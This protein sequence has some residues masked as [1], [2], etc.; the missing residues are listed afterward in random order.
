MNVHL[1]GIHVV[2]PQKGARI[3]G[4]GIRLSGFSA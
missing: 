2:L 4:C 1:F 3:L